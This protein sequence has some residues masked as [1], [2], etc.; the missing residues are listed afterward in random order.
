MLYVTYPC[1][2]L[3]YVLYTQW[4]VPQ[5]YVNLHD[6]PLSPFWLRFTRLQGSGS[7]AL[8]EWGVSLCEL[9]P[10]FKLVIS[11]ICSPIVNVIQGLRVTLWV[12]HNIYQG[13]EMIGMRS[14]LW[15]KWSRTIIRLIFSDSQQ[16]YRGLH[17]T[18][19]SFSNSNCSREEEAW[20]W[21]W[22]VV[23]D[24]KSPAGPCQWSGRA[25]WDHE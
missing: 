24:I 2:V 9:S 1:V 18:R 25:P 15:R 19:S 5:S 3:A 23:A 16:F 7:Q 14:S 22:E 4:S 17:V 6:L 13:F 11:W 12:F 8:S 20:A 21:A 10:P